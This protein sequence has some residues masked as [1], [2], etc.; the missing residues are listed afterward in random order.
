[1]LV[2]ILVVGV[3]EPDLE[4]EYLS[5]V[6]TAKTSLHVYACVAPSV[7]VH[8]EFCYIRILWPT[9]DFFCRCE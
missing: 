3:D 1:M 7:N 2:F 9:E 8:A 4:L 5:F 6:R